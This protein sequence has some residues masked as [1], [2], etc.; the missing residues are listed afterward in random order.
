MLDSIRPATGRVP[1][2]IKFHASSGR[3]Y[4][5]LHP[6]SRMRG[7]MSK[8]SISTEQKAALDRL[9]KIAKA[10]SGGGRR[11]AEFLLAWWN[12]PECGGFDMTSLW[13]VDPSV[14][15]DMVKAFELISTTHKY[16]DQLGYEK[17]FEHIIAVWRP[18]LVE[19][20]ESVSSDE[21]RDAGQ[22]L[23]DEMRDHYV[24]LL[25][26]GVKLYRLTGNSDSNRGVMDEESAIK[27]WL[28][29]LGLS[30]H[31][32]DQAKKLGYIKD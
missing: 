22:S 26:A 16:P 31:L 7:D 29:H 12:A 14:A 1:Y 18:G 11:A 30:P 8:A 2:A 28:K 27:R 5:W 23:Q 10:D 19:R 15:A 6:G 21:K 24:A 17:D 25:S 13:G 4:T 20:T 32:Y 3:F 9:V